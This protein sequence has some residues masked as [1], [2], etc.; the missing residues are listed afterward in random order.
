M[1]LT[2]MGAAISRILALAI[3][4]A[5]VIWLMIHSIRNAED[6]LRM[7]FKWVLTWPLVAL[8]LLSLNLL[9]AYAP[10]LI[11]FCGIILSILWT[12]HIIPFLFQPLTGAFDGGNIPPDPAPLYSIARSKQKQGRYLEAVTDVRQQLE[13]FPTDVEG[14]L[15][16]A[17]IQAEDLKD[18]PGAELT[19][20]HFCAQPGHAPK[21]LVYALYSLADWHLKLGQDREAAQRALEKI[22]E[23]LPD[24][25]FSLG[26]AQRIAHL[27]QTEQ[28]LAPHEEKKFAVPEGVRN[29]GLLQA[30]DQPKTAAADPAQLAAQY[31]SHL[32]QHPLDTEA[33][34]KLAV[35]YVDHYHRLDLA[36]AELEQLIVEPNQ[37]DKLVVHWLNLLADLQIRSGAPYET[38]R[39][40][41]QRIVE[42][43]PDLAA[44]E[45]ARHR[46]S[47]LRLELKAAEKTGAVK[48]G[49]Y[50]QKLG[51]KSTPRPPGQRG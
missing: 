3:G 24:T 32:E 51:L 11:A 40:T 21:N 9:G 5:L 10:M 19:I 8:I 17:Q 18:L 28:L 42:R 37:P 12:P 15:L 39:D 35:L 31:V 23:L 20:H 27:A 34:E 1:F 38:V 13:R 22:I 30:R 14:H 44:A 43:H 47:L 46:L 16:L 49:T 50:E 26:A 6:P 36:T 4:L 45:M 48:M 25:E 33:R 7:I 2:I 29:L 41:L